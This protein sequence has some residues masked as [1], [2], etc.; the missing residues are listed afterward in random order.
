MISMKP[1]MAFLL[2]SS[3]FFM[4]AKAQTMELKSWTGKET[5]PLIIYFSGDGGLNQFSTNLCTSLSDEGYQVLA[6]NAKS[7]FWN[8][9][10]PLKT[11]IDLEKSCHGFENRQII[12]A[13][14]SF[15]ADVLPFIYNNLSAVFKKRVKSVILISPSGSTDFEIHISDMFGSNAKRSMDVINEINKMDVVQLS[16]INGNDEKDIGINKIVHK[17][18]HHQTLPGGHHFEGDV[19]TLRTS[20]MKFF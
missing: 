4:N 9:K 8:K 1:I 6:L 10:D 2:L 19:N 13:G 16:I 17:N 20:M 7:Y 14:Y 11:A 12:L 15:G 18:F 5:L 3:I